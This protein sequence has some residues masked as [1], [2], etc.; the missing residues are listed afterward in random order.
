MKIGHNLSK[1]DHF[2]AAHITNLSLHIDTIVG[3]RA[4]ISSDTIG[5][6][7]SHHYHHHR[8]PRLADTSDTVIIPSSPQPP[9]PII[10]VTSHEEDAA[11]G[12]SDVIEG[13]LDRISHDLDYLL[14]RTANPP[15]T[16]QIVGAVRRKQNEQSTTH[17]GSIVPS[18][19][20]TIPIS[21][22]PQQGQSITYPHSVQEVII[23][24]VEE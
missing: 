12:S 15:E 14:N 20:A 16:T 23:E 10:T 13:M 1:I 24:A 8:S 17:L 6:H 3:I 7:H 4:R 21:H 18:T 5:H 22:A 19:V 2:G 11:A 9:L